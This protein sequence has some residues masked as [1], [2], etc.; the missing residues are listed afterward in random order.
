MD[1]DRRISASL[2][3]IRTTSPFFG[4]LSLFAKYKP[5]KDIPTACT[6]GEYIFFNE[7]FMGQLDKKQLC[8]VLLHELLHCAL[9]HTSPLRKGLRDGA[10]WNIAADVVV[11]NI[12]RNQ[13]A[14]TLPKGSVDMQQFSDLSVEQIYEK[15]MASKKRPDLEYPDLEYSV[16]KG[17]QKNQSE[18][19][20]N[21]K[22][23]ELE[24]KW[25]TALNQAAVTENL[26][27]GGNGQGVG[28]ILG[29]REYD[30]IMEPQLDWRSMLRRFLVRTPTDFSG[31]DRRFVHQGLY[32][33]ELSGESV[34]VHVA[35][36]TS[37]SISSHELSEFAGELKGILRSYP[38]I[39][40]DLYFAD[41]DVDGPY[42]LTSQSDLPEPT[43]GGG[44]SFVPFFK[45]VD[46]EHDEY[47]E[48]ACIYL[49]DG[50]GDFPEDFKLPTL[51]VVTN[52]GLDNEQFP[53]GS[54]TRLS[55]SSLDE[56]A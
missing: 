40:C 11:N 52:N 15:L 35:I 7:D 24:G 8:G 42:K 44:T 21:K 12:I 49:T 32:L 47:E 37:G 38:H 2:L 4:C 26:K 31:F 50:Y 28:S 1:F 46:E 41:Y 19:I 30:A 22:L 23:K 3:Q 20:S 53:F 55:S 39:K 48:G 29:T 17:K 34:R 56:A 10:L 43:G 13:A 36:D 16:L 27:N 18:G 51:W 54:V 33:E 6:D 9:L 25:K 5:R 45:K 14:F